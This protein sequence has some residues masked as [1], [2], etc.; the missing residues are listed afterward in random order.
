M[1]WLKHAF[2]V[3]PPGAAEPTPEQAKVVEWLC[4]QIVK[5]HLT[6]PALAALE[7]SRPLNYIGSQTLHFF[8]PFVSAIQSKHGHEGYCQFA[9]YLE[10]R[11]SI[12]YICHRIEELEDECEQNARQAS[13]E[14]GSPN[15]EHSV[16]EEQNEKD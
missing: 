13:G 7:M 9:T 2:A 16:K 15:K 3:D 4:G 11:G 1:K 5:R 8:Q 10:K 14:T 6:T 12:E